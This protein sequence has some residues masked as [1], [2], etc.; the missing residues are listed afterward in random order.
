MLLI[1]KVRH[2]QNL[3]WHP[4]C[5]GERAA[6]AGDAGG[7]CTRSSG[8]SKKLLDVPLVLLER[9]REGMGAVRLGDEVEVVRVRRVDNRGDGGHGRRRDRP[10]R[11]APGAG[12]G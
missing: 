4:A 12:G 2:N 11:R 9:L 3:Y 1:M 8:S 6:D 7:A 5:A 10:G